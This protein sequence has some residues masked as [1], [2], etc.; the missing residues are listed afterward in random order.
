MA[1]GGAG[2]S[3]GGRNQ[4][5]HQL[6]NRARGAGGYR[7][8]G[9]G[10]GRG[11]DVQDTAGGRDGRGGAGIPGDNAGSRLLVAVALGLLE[12][13]E[14]LAVAEVGV[15][16]VEAVVTAATSMVQ[17]TPTAWDMTLQVL[18]IAEEKISERHR[19]E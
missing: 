9:R 11:G 14:V 16:L 19:S 7:G 17:A 10:R 12:A 18:W 2:R 8:R 13:V 15:V 4:G 6:N 3:S 5:L 1:G